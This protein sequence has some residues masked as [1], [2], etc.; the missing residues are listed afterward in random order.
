MEAV[1]PSFG[2]WHCTMMP[3]SE[4][5]LKTSLSSMVALVRLAFVEALVAKVRS[6][7]PVQV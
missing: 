6:W 2:F 7:M 4:G 3:A 1:L 5:K